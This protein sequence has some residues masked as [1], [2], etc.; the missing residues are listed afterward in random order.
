[1]GR[2]NNRR[3]GRGRGGRFNNRS[4]GNGT[5][6]KKTLE[7]HCFYVGSKK[8]ASDFEVTYE[9]LVNYIKRTYD[10]GNDIAE[11]LRNMR[12]P[13]TNI[14]KP[15][16][17]V[18]LKTEAE[19]V[20]K[21]SRQFELDYKAEYDEYMK[22]KRTFED[23]CYKAYAEIWARCNKAMKAKIESRKD[24]ESNVYN[25]PVN[26]LEEI[27]EHALNYEESQYEMS[28]TLDAITALIHCKQKDK[29]SLQ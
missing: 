12:L 20:K 25:K 16:L 19:D 7:D 10:R 13:E 15:S 1:M 18:S 9:F 11:A 14:W 24:Y 4:N 22:R 28:I 3:A 5:K 6:K 17:E 27:K 23:N 2:T 26:L 8:Q 29:E 21:E